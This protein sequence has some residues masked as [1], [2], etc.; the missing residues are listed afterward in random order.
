MQVAD[1]HRALVAAFPSEPI[2][3]T[4]AFTEWGITYLDGDSFIAGTKGRCWP[5]LTSAFVEEHEDALYFLGPRV[6]VDVL[7]AYLMAMFDPATRDG[8]VPET[9]LTV[10]APPTARG[11][12]SEKQY[13][14]RMSALDGP[15]RAA[16]LMAL[17]ML[18]GS[19]STELAQHVRRARER[20]VCFDLRKHVDRR[21]R[22]APP[23]ADA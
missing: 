22:G 15:Q 12:F 6:F 4:D 21:G 18:E 3:P 2:D 16:L 13:T 17:G 19:G 23:E 9:V 5:S 7:P 20:V 14:M 11:G 8:V 1:V 10:L